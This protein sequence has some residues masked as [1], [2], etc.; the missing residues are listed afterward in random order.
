MK[1]HHSLSDWDFDPKD[2][3]HTDESEYV[4]PPTSL[5]CYDTIQEGHRWCYLKQA[6]IDDLPEGRFV[7]VV[8]SKNW[9]PGYLDIFL[10]TQALPT[11]YLPENGY[12]IRIGSGQLKIYRIV[13]GATTSLKE[14]TPS[15]PPQ[16][17]VWEKWRVT[18][19]QYI[20]EDLETVFRIVVE[21]EVSG[22]WKEQAVGEDPDNLW[23]ESGVNRIGFGLQWALDVGTTFLDDTE[24]WKRVAE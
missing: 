5:T 2:D 12:W 15:N 1:K 17:H 23:A 14:T 20:N 3:W 10:R 4:S 8:K 6:V 24:I 18:F 7:T 11:D 22:E 9:G 16:E 21:K 19:W 13:N